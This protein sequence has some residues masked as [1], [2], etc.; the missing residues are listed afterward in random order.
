MSIINYIIVTLYGFILTALFIKEPKN[1]FC[2]MEFTAFYIISGIINLFLY[3]YLGAKAV[4]LLYPLTV[5]IPL[6]ICC[7]AIIKTPPYEALSNAKTFIKFKALQK[8]GQICIMSQTDGNAVYDNVMLSAHK[9]AVL[10]KR[11]IIECAKDQYK[12][13]I[14]LKI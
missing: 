3:I 8:G 12:I 11:G 5:H 14:A 6:P 2:I 4:F 9:S 7:I 10:K 13:Q 1:K